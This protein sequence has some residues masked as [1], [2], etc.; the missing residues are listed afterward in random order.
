MSGG[1]RAEPSV[2][3]DYVLPRAGDDRT[4]ALFRAGSPCQARVAS[5]SGGQGCPDTRQTKQ[6]AGADPC[7]AAAG[8]GSHKRARSGPRQRKST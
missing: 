1:G 3:R 8:A 5:E 7:A 6:R 2:G 4:S